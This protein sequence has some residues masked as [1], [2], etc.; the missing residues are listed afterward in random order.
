MKEWMYEWI[1]KLIEIQGHCA[2]H[3]C[4]KCKT[5]FSEITVS[6]QLIE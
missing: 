6:K 5:L 2:Y 1:N 4:F 3:M